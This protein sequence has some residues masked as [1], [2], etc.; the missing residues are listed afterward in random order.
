M[1]LVAVSLLA[2]LSA[3]PGASGGAP[4]APV[5]ADARVEPS[6]RLGFAGTFGFDLGFTDLLEVQLDDGS[7]RSITANQGVF[8]SAG[9]SFLPLLG[10]KL[11]TQATLG[12]K[13]SGI[14]AAN[15]SASFL[16][17]PLEIL[18]TFH[19]APV[20]LSAGI[21]YLLAPRASGDGVLAGFDVDFENSLGLVLQ[22]EW[23]LFHGERGAM[24]VGPRFVWQKLQVKGD[25]PVL[26]ASAFGAVMSFTLR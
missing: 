6:S 9:A 2:L 8:A 18:E 12:L 15:G 16:A 13:Y 3:A 21:V 19:L 23:L 7:S 14:D 26:D 4:L 24:S 22:G 11:W 1:P 5:V 25:G 10:G 17:F 20:R